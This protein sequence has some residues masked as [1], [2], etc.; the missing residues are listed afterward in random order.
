MED[1]IDNYHYFSIET[2][3]HYACKCGAWW[4]IGDGPTE[5]KLYCPECGKYS[6]VKEVE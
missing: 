6:E 2:L 5:N 4:T 1:T 3:V